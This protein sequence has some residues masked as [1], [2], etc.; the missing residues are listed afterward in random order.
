MIPPKLLTFSGKRLL[1]LLARYNAALLLIE[2]LNESGTHSALSQA[3]KDNFT[4]LKKE[5]KD[6]IAKLN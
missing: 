4:N 2:V 6:S 5:L 1:K 3:T